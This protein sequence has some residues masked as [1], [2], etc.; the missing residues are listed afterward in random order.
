MFLDSPRFPDL[1]AYGAR[2]GPRYSTSI[3]GTLDD[4]ETRNQNWA[5]PLAQYQVGLVHRGRALTEQLFA[6]FRTVAQGRTNTF[7]FRDPLPGEAEGVGEILGV[8]DGTK[9]TFRLVKCYRSGGLVMPRRIT[10]PVAG[11]VQVCVD[12]TPVAPAS[13]VVDTVQGL[14]TIPAPAAGA[15]VTASFQFDVPVRFETDQLRLERVAPEVWSW[16]SITLV[17]ERLMPEF[18]VGACSPP[19][20]LGCRRVAMHPTLSQGL[21]YCWDLDEASGPRVDHIAHVPLAEGGTPTASTLGKHGQAAVFSGTNWLATSGGAP[22]FTPPFTLACWL[23]M[24]AYPAAESYCVVGQGLTLASGQ[25][26]FYLIVRP[27]DHR[28][29]M[30]VQGGFRGLVSWPIPPSLGTWH[31]VIGWHAS[32]VAGDAGTMNLQVDNALPVSAPNGTN[33]PTSTNFVL[34]AMGSL[35]SS[36]ARLVGHLDSVMFWPRVLTPLERVDLWNGG[37][38]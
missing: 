37:Q 20:L 38:G 5:Y 14:V 22:V 28:L 36:S 15:V 24:S 4:T 8:G 23:W 7:R 32:L 17:E 35:G 10:K 25:Y 9:T 3:V 12:G 30:S 11:T 19:P 18:D 1:I 33:G 16:E 6:F 2:G 34:G 21:T 31:L 29:Q 13:L 26:G 27:D